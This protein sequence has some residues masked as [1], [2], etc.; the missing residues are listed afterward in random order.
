MKISI[1]GKTDIG[2]ERANN[3]DA[4][5][6]CT[7]LTQSN[8]INTSSN[9]YIRNGVYGSISIIA[10]GMGGANAGEMASSIA[11]ESIKK[12]LKPALLSNV[13]KSDREIKIYLNQIVMNANEAILKYIDTDPNTIGMGTTIALIWLLNEKAYIAWCGD[14]RCYVFNPKKGLKCLSKDHSFVQELIDK[15]KITVKQSFNHPDSSIIT[16][17]LGDCDTSAKLDIIVYNI[18]KNDQF[19]LC[20]DGLCGYCEDRIIEKI[21]YKEYL[22]VNRCC[23]ALVELALEAGGQDNISVINIST[24]GDDETKIPYSLN[25]RIKRFFNSLF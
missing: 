9:G 25:D 5:S 7:D 16:R 13:I 24:I 18:N 21:F 12:D 10:D 23:N 8:W 15:G 14:S 20:S 1:S 3:E 2:F 19:L 4:F 17:C 6:F 22:N 11:I